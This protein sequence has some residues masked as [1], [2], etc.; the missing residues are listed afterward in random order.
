MRIFVTGTSGYIGGSIAV[1]LAAAGHEVS[2]LVRSERSAEL[3]RA[4]GIIPVHGTLGG[5]R[6][7]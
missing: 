6:Y 4:F 3:V 1:A 2:G 7:R 5:L